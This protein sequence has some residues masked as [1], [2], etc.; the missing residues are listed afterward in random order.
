MG[1]PFPSS[2][3]LIRDTH[4]DYLPWLF[5]VDSVF[6]VLGMVSSVIV[7][8]SYGFSGVLILGGISYVMAFLVF[9]GIR[10]QY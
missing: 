7:A 2:I 1:V 10:F 5:G 4:Q 8:L 3:R 6:S 9:R